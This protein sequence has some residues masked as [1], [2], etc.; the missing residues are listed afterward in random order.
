VT[1]GGL[2]GL[3]DSWVP[4]VFHERNRLLEGWRRSV[5]KLLRAALRCGQLVSTLTTEELET[6]LAEQ[7]NRWWSVKIQSF[8]SKTHFL[9]YAGRYVR[10]PPIAQKRVTHVDKRIVRFWY[11][12]K[13]LRRRM[14]VEVTPEMRMRMDS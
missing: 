10:R 5:I 13:K 8:K 9:G 11:K 1:A 3:S 7:E 12:D 14:D 6:L 2:Y 4:T